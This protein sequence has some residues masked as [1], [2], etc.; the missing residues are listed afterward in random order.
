MNLTSRFVRLSAPVFALILLGQGC[1]GGGQ[2]PAA[3]DG[4][5]YRTRNNG[6]EWKQLR[7]LNLG[8]KIASLAELG[9]VT[10]AVDPQD[11]QAL[12]AGT[13]ENG[14]L[15]SLDGGESWNLAKGLSTGKVNAVAV[16]PKDKC[17]VY[18]AKA[19]QI[20]KTVNCSRDWNQVYFDSRTAIAFT[21]LAVDHFNPN[22]VYS[23][24]SDGDIFRSDD[25]GATWRR[26]HRVDGVRIQSL[27]MDPRDSRVLFAASD[28]SGIYKTA[29]GGT[30]WERIIEPF[31]EYDFARRPRMVVLDPQTKD[32]LYNVSKYGLIR[33]A[34]AGATWKPLTLPTPPGAVDIKALAIH[35]KNSRFLV[36]A[37]DTSIVF[38]A[39]GGLTWTPK[40]L[41]TTRGVSSLLFDNAAEMGLF[42]GVAPAKK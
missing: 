19:N 30:T 21:A 31:K 39:D 36:Y 4:G 10:L 40:K 28:G 5:I 33:S 20:H 34:D 8:T 35:P 1:L 29:D 14:L 42:L 2:R 26:V 6:Q 25:G 16:D 22:I 41:P 37:T 24:T 23:A 3:Q 7:V 18:A 12:Y 17:T 15:F 32:V 38:S 27:A 9:T 13:V 11:P